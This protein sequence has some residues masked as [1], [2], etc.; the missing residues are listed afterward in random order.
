[1]T[2][3]SSIEISE[4][5]LRRAL[6]NAEAAQAALNAARASANLPPA[7]RAFFTREDFDK[8]VAKRAEQPKPKFGVIIGGRSAADDFEIDAEIKEWEN[9]P[10]FAGLKK[11]AYGRAFLDGLVLGRMSYAPRFREAQEREAERIR[12]RDES[13]EARS[14]AAWADMLVKADALLADRGGAAALLKQ[15]GGRQ[16]TA[17][18]ILNAGARARGEQNQGGSR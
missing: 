10:R 1:M 6:L 14:A 5:A 15:S 18:E 17:A 12:Q 13:P 7:P 2:T 11:T 16:A 8:A 3:T 9:S 4:S